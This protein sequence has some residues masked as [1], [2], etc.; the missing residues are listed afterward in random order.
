MA[1]MIPGCKVTDAN[2]IVCDVKEI[3][4]DKRVEY[5]EQAEFILQDGKLYPVNEAQLPE[6]TLLKLKRHIHRYWGVK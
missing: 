2:R 4:G 3:T 1:R 5:G 6:D